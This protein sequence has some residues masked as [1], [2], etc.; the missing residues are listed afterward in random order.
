MLEKT[1]KSVAKMANCRTD[2]RTLAKQRLLK[3][4]DTVKRCRLGFAFL[5]VSGA[6]ACVGCGNQQSTSGSSLPAD[7][8]V[9]YESSPVSSDRRSSSPSPVTSG[10]MESSGP[11]S[12]GA[13]AEFAGRSDSAKTLTPSRPSPAPS[14]NG[15]QSGSLTAGSFDDVSNFSD[16]Q[17]FLRRYL[18]EAQRCKLPLDANGKQTLIT[19]TDAA[20]KP[21]GDA[22]CVVTFHQGQQSQAEEI[23]VDSTTGT[24][25]RL[26][27]ISNQGQRCYGR[28]VRIQVSL[29]GQQTPVFE[30]TTVLGKQLR[31]VLDESQ[32]SLPQQL[33][34]A[35]VIDTTGSMGDELEY[36]KT[37][38]DSI[39]ASVNDMFPNVDQRYALITYRDNGDEY[40]CRSFDFTTS[41]NDFRENLNR[42]SAAGGGDFPEAMD[43]ALQNAEQL[44]WRTLNTAKVLFLV[45]DAPPHKQNTGRALNA[46]E[47]LRQKGVRMFPV[48]ASGVET[49][50][51][52]VMRT[53]ALLTMGQYLFLT[54]H[55]GVGNAHATP[56]VPEFA[57]ERLDRLMI[58]MIASE[59]A[60]RRLVAE[61]VIAIEQGDL[62]SLN[63]PVRCE[64][65]VACG[66]EPT[67]VVNSASVVG[68]SHLAFAFSWIGDH[69]LAVMLAMISVVVVFD[70]LAAS[71]GCR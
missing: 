31:I 45:G 57:V 43:A 33:D 25:G 41:L 48:G 47:G 4:T 6:M 67:Y 44:S 55:S 22:R 8:A 13:V 15:L 5:V 40:V 56:D 27:F 32:S 62:Y 29:A 71:R 1:C 46:V 7:V 34:L 16:Y 60:G 11:V 69:G 52:I 3:H 68:S 39:V 20:G 21:I 61:E 63:R 66:P 23:L 64:P 51:Q 14:R 26:M 18:S 30:Q 50:A 58:R 36:L 9:S 70:R 59:L 37:E 65:V 38:I 10:A 42:Q 54:D 28:D 12:S 17:Q 35:L 19:V 2:K 53:S 24:D 49:T